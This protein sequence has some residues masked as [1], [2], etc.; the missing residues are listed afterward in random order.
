MLTVRVEGN[1]ND[2]PP[3]LE[4]AIEQVLPWIRR[5]LADDVHLDLSTL[6]DAGPDLVALLFAS[7]LQARARSD[8]V[9]TTLPRPPKLLA[10]LAFSGLLHA[11]GEGPPPDPDHPEC[12]TVPVQSFSGTTIRQS[13]PIVHLITRHTPL[14]RDADERLRGSLREVMQNVIDHARSPVGGVLAARFM[15]GSREVRV[16]IVDLGETIPSAL[17][18]SGTT[19]PAA[20]L[21]N[22]LRHGGLSSRSR[23]HNS[24]LGLHWL[25]QHVQQMNGELFIRSGNIRAT[26][27]SARLHPVIHVDLLPAF[28]PGTGVFFRLKVAPD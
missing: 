20:Q 13:D 6:H 8:N 1:C 17:A 21:R 3:S 19:D 26:A 14:S 18:R 22:H 25:T 23:P 2:S 9:R 24:G 28:F 11:L 5:P 4:A 15:R 27:Q 10:F 16:A 7:L 12:E